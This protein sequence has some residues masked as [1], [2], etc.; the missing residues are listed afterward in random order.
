MKLF[1]KV[2]DF[3]CH[4]AP[5]FYDEDG[6]LTEVSRKLLTLYV[7]AMF[8]TDLANNAVREI[9]KKFAQRCVEQLPKPCSGVV[10]KAPRSAVVLV[11]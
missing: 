4:G 1:P 8:G 9:T 6:E 3:V 2:N 10:P 11:G 7:G 5:S